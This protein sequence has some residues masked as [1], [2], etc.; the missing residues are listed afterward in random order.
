MRLRASWP[1]RYRPP[2]RPLALMARIPVLATDIDPA[3]Y[4]SLVTRAGRETK[5]QE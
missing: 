5:G 4:F 1:Q 2:W 3:V